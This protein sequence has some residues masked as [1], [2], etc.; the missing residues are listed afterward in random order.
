M[1]TEIELFGSRALTNLDFCLWGWKR[2]EVYKRKVDI[3]HELLARNLNRTAA[4]IK[5]SEDAQTIN[6]QSSHTSFICFAL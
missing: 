1:V 6:T 5:K 2:N 3:R 4:C